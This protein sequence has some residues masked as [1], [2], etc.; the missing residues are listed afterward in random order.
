MNDELHKPVDRQQSPCTTPGFSPKLAE[1]LRHRLT[2]SLISTLVAL[3]A[4]Y[5]YLFPGSFKPVTLSAGE[6]QVLENKLVRLEA[7]QR[8]PALHSKRLNPKPGGTLQPKRYSESGA[9]REIVLT[10][11]ELNALLAKNT[12]LSEKLAIDL[13]QDLASAKLLFPLDEEFPLLGGKTLNVTAGLEMAYRG[14]RPMVALRGI[15]LWGVP[16][17]NAWLD[18]M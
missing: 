4:V 1:A 5:L 16:I 15:S 18:N 8:S 9:S 13:S 10:E 7:I 6:E 2:A 17:P 12:D 14:E 3:A 11:R